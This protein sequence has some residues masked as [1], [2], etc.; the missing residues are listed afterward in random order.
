[1][2]AALRAE[3]A[4]LRWRGEVMLLDEAALVFG[5][6]MSEPEGWLLLAALVFVAISA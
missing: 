2:L 3:N 5:L 6:L 4:Q 1:M